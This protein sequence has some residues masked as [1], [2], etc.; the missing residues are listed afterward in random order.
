MS[1]GEEDR[2]PPAN[3]F[4]SEQSSL[5]PLN[6]RR[7]GSLLDRLSVDTHNDTPSPSL[8]ERVDFPP[9]ADEEQGDLSS[10]M[11]DVE[12]DDLAARKGGKRRFV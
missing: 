5:R 10:D 11:M 2:L 9:R 1:M 8:R 6:T 7:G 12:L 3:D 4:P